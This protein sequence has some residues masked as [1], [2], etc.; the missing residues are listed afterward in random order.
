MAYNLKIYGIERKSDGEKKD[1][2]MENLYLMSASTDNGL[3][4]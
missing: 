2:T 3:E 4:G 1:K